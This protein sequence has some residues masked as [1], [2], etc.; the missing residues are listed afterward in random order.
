MLVIDAIR[1]AHAHTPEP[2][3]VYSLS[4]GALTFSYTGVND[5]LSSLCLIATLVYT[6]IKIIK[7]TR[8]NPRKS[9]EP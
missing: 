9:D 6:V 5:F 2:V 3:K 7:A 4:L 8:S 1:A